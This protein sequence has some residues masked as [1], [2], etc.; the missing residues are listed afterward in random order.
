MNT[1]ILET[2]AKTIKKLE[3]LSNNDLNNF[4]EIVKKVASLDDD[5]DMDELTAEAEKTHEEFVDPLTSELMVDPVM[6]PNSKYI[7]DRKTIKQQLQ[8]DSCDPFNR[9]PLTIEEVIP[10]DDLREQ[11]EDFIA[12][13]R[14][15]K[16]SMMQE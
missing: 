10:Q 3:V 13:Y 14:A 1:S 5:D 2:C 16:M 6:L 7:V 4:Q 8:N 9:S 12:E 15:T 11:I